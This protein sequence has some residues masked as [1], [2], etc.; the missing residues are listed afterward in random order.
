MTANYCKDCNR[1]EDFCLCGAVEQTD[2]RPQQKVTV[3]DVVERSY[4]QMQLFER[5]LDAQ[6][7]LIANMMLAYSEVTST[8][9]ALILEVLAPRSEE[10]K[11]EFRKEAKKRH[12]ELLKA[13]QEVT[14]GMER[15]GP[16]IG[17]AVEGVVGEDDSPTAE[18]Q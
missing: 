5:R 12:F 2:H 14:R 16:D 10:E 13:M 7:E 3:N 15:S 8:V 17:S 1:L 6:E 11:E 4:Q 18:P 9:E